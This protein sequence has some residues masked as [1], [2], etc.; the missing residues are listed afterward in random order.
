MA[1]HKWVALLSLVGRAED[2]HSILDTE[3]EATLAYLD[4]WM[5]ARGGR[6]GRCQ[7]PRADQW[8]AL[9]AHPPLHL[10]RW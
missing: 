8:F 4:A 5:A 6:R 7:T 1:A 10:P 3:A 2:M 9:A